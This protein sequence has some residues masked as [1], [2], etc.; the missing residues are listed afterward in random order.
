M[1]NN[2]LKAFFADRP[3]LSKAK[4]AEEAGIGRRT[5]TYYL[6]H[7]PKPLTEASEKKLKPI[8]KKYGYTE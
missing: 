4:I 2:D 5:L 3:A 7:D 6:Q 8:L 1:T